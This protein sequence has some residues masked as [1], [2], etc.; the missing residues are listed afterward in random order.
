MALRLRHERGPSFL[1]E[2]GEKRAYRQNHDR[3]TSAGSTGFDKNAIDHCADA[4]ETLRVGEIIIAAKSA[5]GAAL[6]GEQGE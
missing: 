6:L 5:D 1:H 4:A 3:F 2:V